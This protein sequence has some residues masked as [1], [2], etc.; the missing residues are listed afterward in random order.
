MIK[1]EFFYCMQC[2]LFSYTLQKMLQIPAGLLNYFNGLSHF[3]LI[4]SCLPHLKA[5]AIIH[6]SHTWKVILC[7]W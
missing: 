4:S 2:D 7:N 3:I 6:N 5:A 1:K